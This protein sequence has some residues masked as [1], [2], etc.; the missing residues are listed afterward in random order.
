MTSKHLPNYEMTIQP[1]SDNMRRKIVFALFICLCAVSAVSADNTSPS[2]KSVQKIQYNY[3]GDYFEQTFPHGEPF[4]VYT[5]VK[6]QEQRPL[7]IYLWEA[8]FERSCS[9]KVTIYD[10]KAAKKIKYNVPLNTSTRLADDHKYFQRVHEIHFNGP[11]LDE[12]TKEIT[13]YANFPSLSYSKRYCYRIVRPRQLT[14]IEKDRIYNAVDDMLV[15]YERTKN[16]KK[17]EIEVIYRNKLVVLS[18]E[19]KEFPKKLVKLTYD[20]PFKSVI[21][22][23]SRLNGID[24]EINSKL[25]FLTTLLPDKKIQNQNADMILSPALIKIRT[26]PRAD[27]FGE[28]HLKL[29]NRCLDDL[30]LV[31]RQFGVTE[32]CSVMSEINNTVKKI[33]ELYNERKLKNVSVTT[34]L[35]AFKK[36]LVDKTSIVYSVGPVKTLDASQTFTERGSWYFSADLGVLAV[37]FYQEDQNKNWGHTGGTDLATYVGVNMYFAPVDKDIPLR[38]DDGILRR[39][40]LTFGYSINPIQDDSSSLEGILNKNALIT[41]LGFRITDYLRITPGIVILK[42]KHK[43]PFVDNSYPVVSPFIGASIDVD[44]IGT[45]KKLAGKATN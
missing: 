38:D 14:D 41:G 5:K 6:V 3:D 4:I 40:S 26:L 11:E 16:I 39:M 21:K 9:D 31:C 10:A 24:R 19:D 43:N 7:K 27:Q 42:Q 28:E 17:D 29:V 36:E 23:Q 13:Y 45:I 8:K 32:I 2:V 44:M 1:I 35:D 37:F 20:T 15:K 33:N 18:N 30:S 22:T 12:K 25:T 34:S